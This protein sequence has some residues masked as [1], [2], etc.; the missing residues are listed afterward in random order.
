MKEEVTTREV[1]RS[2]SQDVRRTLLQ[3]IALMRRARRDL[4][5]CRR[6]TRGRQEGV[7]SG[8]ISVIRPEPAWRER[9]G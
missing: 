9:D 8:S 1:P 5:R 6:T 7:A 2:G 3:S 4:V